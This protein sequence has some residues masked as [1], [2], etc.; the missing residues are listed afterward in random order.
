MASNPSAL[1]A[2]LNTDTSYTRARRDVSDEIKQ[3]VEAA[4]SEWLKDQG[5]WRSITFATE[6]D[7]NGILE[8]ARQYTNVLRDTPLTVQTPGKPE[9]TPEG[10][11]VVYRVRNKVRA[12][13]KPN[14][15]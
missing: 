12:G 2:A 10:L 4:Y 11:K 6:D 8:D 15:K 14:G 9:E 13:R 7:M 3:W 1:A 5:S